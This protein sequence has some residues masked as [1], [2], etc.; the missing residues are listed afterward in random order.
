MRYDRVTFPNHVAEGEGVGGGEWWRAR[1]VVEE[2]GRG[3]GRCWRMVVDSE[4]GWRM[5]DWWWRAG[6]GRKGRHGQI[7]T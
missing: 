7:S 3:R 4:G 5:V 6:K 1:Q 2:W